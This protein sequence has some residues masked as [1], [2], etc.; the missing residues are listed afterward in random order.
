MLYIKLVPPWLGP[1]QRVGLLRLQPRYRGSGNKYTHFTATESKSQ[2]GRTTIRAF[3]WA[4]VYQ[5]RAARLA[6]HSQRP[7]YLQS[8]IQHWLTFVL[9]ILMTALVV[10]LVGTVVAR[11]QQLDIRA[12][13]VGVSLVI[14]TGLGETLTRLI[15]TWTRLESSIGAV[16]RVRRFVAETEV[17]DGGREPE[18]AGGMVALWPRPGAVEFKGVVAGFTALGSSRRSSLSTADAV[19]KAITLSVQPDEHLAICGRSGSG[20]TSLL[21]ALFRMA[22]VLEG[23]ILVEGQEVVAADAFAAASTVRFNLDPFSG[24][25]SEEELVGAL[26]RVGLW[27]LVQAQGGLDTDVDALALSGGQQQLLCFVRAIVKRRHCSILVLDEA[28]CSLDSETEALVQSNIDS[29]FRKCTVLAVMHK[30]THIRA[31]DRVAVL[32]GGALVKVGTPADLLAADTRLAGLNRLH[33]G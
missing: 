23:R 5:R 27:G 19:L 2:S 13:G 24:A 4:H 29:A 18:T 26:H 11:G 10:V 28:T 16:T 25:A 33:G 20:K 14:L 12:G 32:D 1:T 7:A 22:E 31:Y 8:C 30:M 15:R 9:N 21:L 3:G 6:D 17:E